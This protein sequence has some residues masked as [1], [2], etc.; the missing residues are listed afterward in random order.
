LI[1]I[2]GNKSDNRSIWFPFGQWFFQR[3]R[4][5]RLVQRRDFLL[6][7]ENV[8]S[9]NVFQFKILNNFPGNRAETHAKNDHCQKQ[10]EQFDGRALNFHCLINFAAKQINKS[11]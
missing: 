5:Q 8:F 9:I 11:S 4:L 6:F 10:P 1:F 7:R 2:S 3:V